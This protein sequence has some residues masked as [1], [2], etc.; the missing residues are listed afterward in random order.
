MQ[1]A[2]STGPGVAHAIGNVSCETR[3]PGSHFSLF[4]PVV[5]REHSVCSYLG[6]TCIYMIGPDTCIKIQATKIVNF[7]IFH[8]TFS[9][10]NHPPLCV[11]AI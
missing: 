3:D 4:N 2:L 1:P 8:C 7:A 9:L 6:E 11:A 5:N 10:N